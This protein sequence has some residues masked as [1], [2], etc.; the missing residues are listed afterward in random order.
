MNVL[1]TGYP[2]EHSAINVLPDIKKPILITSYHKV[3][4]AF[5]G[6]FGNSHFI[7]LNCCLSPVDP[8]P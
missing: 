3:L 5:L 1:T 4:Q 6:V 2:K 7:K 8:Y